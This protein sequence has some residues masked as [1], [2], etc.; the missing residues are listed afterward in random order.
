MSHWNAR[1]V[2]VPSACLLGNPQLSCIQCFAELS[3]GLFH[4]SQCIRE[5]GHECISQSLIRVCHSRSEC[6]SG[7]QFAYLHDIVLMGEFQY[8]NTTIDP[9]G[10]TRNPLLHSPLLIT[11]VFRICMPG[12][13]SRRDVQCRA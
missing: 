2:E 8:Y 4:S 1:W 10:L 5:W 12:L 6:Y 11:L 13:P 3:F 9:S 7:F